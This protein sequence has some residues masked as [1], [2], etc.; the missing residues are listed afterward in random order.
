MK[1]LKKILLGIVAFFAILVIVGFF[2]PS[3]IIVERSRVIDAPIEMI[4]DQVNNLHLWEKWS[5]WHKIDPNMQITYTNS[6][7]GKDASYSWTSDHKSVGNGMLTITDAKPFEFIETV[8]DFG[9]KGSGTANFKFSPVEGGIEVSWD[10]HS[11]IGKKPFIRLMGVIMKK[12]IRDAYDRGLDD[13]D[14]QCQYLKSTDW[15]YVKIK[16]KPGWKYYGISN[17]KTTLETMQPTMEEFYG[18]LYKQ[19]GKAQITP[20]GSAFAAYYSWGDEFV[21]ECGVPVDDNTT[22][23]K[24]IEAKEMPEQTYAALKL[25]GNYDRLENAHAYLMQ[26]LETYEL[27]LAG[28]VIEKYKVGPESTTNP[29]EWVTYILYPV[30]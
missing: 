15:F 14:T 10:M 19:L 18:K 3:E 20:D 1:A 26:W 23:L 12:S 30:K 29:D 5:P 2:M 27:E 13:I 21:M 25:T 7:V 4:Y 22:K 9:E 11:D 28:P 24:G 6:G 8:M 17:K 16:T